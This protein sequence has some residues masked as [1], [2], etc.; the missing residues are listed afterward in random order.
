MEWKDRR[1]QWRKKLLLVVGKNWNMKTWKLRGLI[2]NYY[3][4]FH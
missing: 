3:I 4:L 1:S 2:P